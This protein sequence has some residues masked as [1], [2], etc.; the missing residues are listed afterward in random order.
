MH[1]IPG[2]GVLSTL[3]YFLEPLAVGGGSTLLQCF[4]FYISVSNRVQIRSPYIAQ[5]HS[6]ARMTIT[7]GE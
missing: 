3:I 1:R 5:A 6:D 2:S 4:W 7:S